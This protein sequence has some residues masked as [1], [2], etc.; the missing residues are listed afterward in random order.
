MR[1]RSPDGAGVVDR[2]RVCKTCWAEL[3]E[4]AGRWGNGGPAGACEKGGDLTAGSGKG[5]P[6]CGVE[7]G[8]GLLG[9]FLVDPVQHTR[10]HTE[11]SARC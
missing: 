5:C 2:G 6:D 4:E 8:G 9:W 1:G 3:P 10:S 7:G 11:C